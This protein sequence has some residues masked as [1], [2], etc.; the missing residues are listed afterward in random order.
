M[1][2]Q[3]TG[4]EPGE[5]REDRPVRP[6][7]LWRLRLCSAQHR[8][9]APQHEYFRGLGPIAAREQHKSAED[10]DQREVEQAPGTS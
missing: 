6:S 1:P 7:Q 8:D 3:L 2:A 4:R 10:P 5:R 9:L